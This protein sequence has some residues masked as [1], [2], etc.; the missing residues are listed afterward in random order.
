MSLI[1]SKSLL[2]ESVLLLLIS[3]PLRASN[4]R[5]A[6]PGGVGSD[7]DRSFC[8]GQ[9]ERVSKDMGEWLCLPKLPRCTKR[10]LIQSCPDLRDDR[11]IV[12]PLRSGDRQTHTIHHGQTVC[13]TKPLGSSQ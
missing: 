2:L 13:L 11:I 12:C 1:S 4:G 9:G 6:H 10:C 5:E 3:S 8:R 7:I